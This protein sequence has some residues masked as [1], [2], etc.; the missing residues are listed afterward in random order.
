MLCTAWRGPAALRSVTMLP[1]LLPS[2][3]SCWGTGEFWPTLAAETHHARMGEQ[4]NLSTAPGQVSWELGVYFWFSPQ[5]SRE[6]NGAEQLLG[7]QSMVLV[8]EADPLGTRGTAGGS[9]RLLQPCP[10]Q[11]APGCAKVALS[12]HPF[13][14]TPAARLLLLW[15]L[16]SSRVVVMKSLYLH[17]VIVHVIKK[18][19]SFIDKCQIYPLSWL[20]N[21]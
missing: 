13:P 6:P 21:S 1:A 8:M 16:P 2:S 9:A 20:N 7:G 10:Q 15:R 11:S 12:D 4:G 18:K 5:R 19:R 14:F 3:S 17:K